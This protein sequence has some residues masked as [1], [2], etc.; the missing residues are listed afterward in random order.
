MEAF[1]NAENES[2]KLKIDQS[3]DHNRR[4][5][6]NKFAQKVQSEDVRS[7]SDGE[8]EREQKAYCGHNQPQNHVPSA[9]SILLLEINSQINLSF[10]IESVYGR[11][12]S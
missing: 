12:C 9:F 7:Y 1:L 8:D 6:S 4:Y 3:V 2:A 10:Y 5:V 11:N